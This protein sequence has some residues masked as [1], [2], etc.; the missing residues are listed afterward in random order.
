METKRKEYPHNYP[1]DAV[2]ILDAMSFTDGKDVKL[3]GSMSLRS[4]QYAGDY[5]AYEV[6]KVDGSSLE[7]ALDRLAK[8]FQI[9]LM[10]LQRLENVWIGDIKSGV[11]EEWEVIPQKRYTFEKAETKLNALLEEKIIDE[12]EYED[13][14]K[15]LKPKMDKLDLIIARKEIKF[16]IIRWSVAEV[17]KGH[18]TLRD[19]RN[20]TLQDAF[21]SP[22]LT[23]LDTIGLVENNRYTDFSMIYEFEYK[24]KTLNP[25]FEDINHSLKEDIYYYKHTGKPFKALKREFALSRNNGDH[26]KLEHLTEILNSDLGRLYALVSDVGTLITLLEDHTKVPIETIKFEVS[27]FKGRM[28]NIYTLN[29]FLKQEPKLLKEV[30]KTLR[31]YTRGAML[32]GLTILKDAFETLLMKNTRK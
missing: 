16:H 30:E 32:K 2:V 15:L 7:V 19:G 3:S 21:H 27:Q 11:I 9:I 25:V 13:A 14:I 23:K 26:T 20:Y 31:S 28:A 18:K 4:Q 5:D 8:K 6:V 10:R 17:L 24:G 12:G 1:D 29:T 22:S